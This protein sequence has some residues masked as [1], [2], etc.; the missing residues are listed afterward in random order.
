MSVFEEWDAESF[1]LGIDAARQTVEDTAYFIVSARKRADWCS[2][3]PG[4]ELIF[5]FALIDYETKVLVQRLMESSEDRYV[6]EKYLALHLYEVIGRAPKAI[7]T[8]IFEMS[9]EETASRADPDIYKQAAKNFRK[10]MRNITQDAEFM[11]ALKIIRNS[12]AAHHA[13]SKTATMDPSIYWMLSSASQRKS[14]GTPLSSQILEYSV[15]AASA[16]QDF[17]STVGGH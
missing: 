14:G 9:R 7:S 13:D 5:Y 16:V 12:V 1:A 3:R 6:W 4:V 2:H 15:K 8:A 17:A 11:N 10:A